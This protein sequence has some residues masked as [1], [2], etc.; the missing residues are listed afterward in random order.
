MGGGARAA[1]QAGVLE[2]IWSILRDEG[3]PAAC[4][5]FQVI[6]GTSAGAINAAALACRADR[7]DEAIGTVLDTWSRV[8]AGDVYR[9]DVPGALSNALHWVLALGFGW[10]VR[11]R[12]RSLFDNT[13]LNG[14]LSRLIDPACLSRAIDS[15]ALHAFAVTASSY[16]SGQHVT[17][18][19]SATPIVP[20]S[21][22][23]RLAC[24]TR[25]G[26]DHLLA[27]SA[28]PFVFPAV[29]LALG[30]RHEYFGDGSIR[31]TAPISPAIHLG[32][33]RILVIG[34]GQLQAGTVHSTHTGS[35]YHYPSLAQ[36][37]GHAMAS[38]FLDALA[39]DI[40]RLSRVNNTLQL[41][42]ESDR[43]ATRLRP[44]DVLA[45]APSERLDAL[46]TEHIHALPR[47]A[48]TLLRMIG[49]TDRRG[50]GLASY[51]LFEPPYTR[52]LIELGRKDT[53]AR[54]DDVR[55]FFAS[56]DSTTNGP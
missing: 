55:R 31:Q 41:I 6:C 1:Y 13:P 11:T 8:R 19:Q 5:P 16:T 43:S 34:A 44:I 21:R 37:A 12:P 52:A 7:I 18:Y 38:I 14:L 9:V 27:S 45:I 10:L 47:T 48:R 33:D 17:Y 22:T 26:V 36:V 20:W 39:G 2:A 24:P 30:D 23:Q 35:Q 46:A 15:G 4:N 56:N 3:W 51:L 25:I 28:I 50:A 42:P 53:F 32:A 54:K 29:A 49:A 40:E